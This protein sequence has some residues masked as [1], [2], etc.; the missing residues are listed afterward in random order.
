MLRSLVI[1][2]CILLLSACSQFSKQASDVA[3]QQAAKVSP[4]TAQNSASHPNRD[5]AQSE[6]KT[7]TASLNASD[8]KAQASNPT[9]ESPNQATGNDAENDEQSDLW[10]HIRDDFRLAHIDHSRI[11]KQKNWYGRHPNYMTRVSKRASPYLYFIVNELKRRDMP[12][13][14]ALLPIVESAYDPF[15]YSHGRA[16]GL[17]QFT[18]PTA[19]DFGLHKNWWYD[20]RR[21]IEASTQAALNY[22]QKL[23]KRFD[24]D[25]LLALAAYNAGGGT[26]NKAIKRN[27][28]RDKATDFWS[29]KLPKET[30]IYVPR[31]LGLSRLVAKPEKNGIELVNVPNKPFYRRFNLDYQLDLAQAAQLAELP[32]DEFYLL[33]PAYNRWATTPDGPQ[34]ILIPVSQANAFASGLDELDQAERVGWTRY[35][36]KNGDTLG[37]IANDHKLSVKELKRIN[38]LSNNTIRKGQ[39]LFIPTASKPGKHYSFSL[40]ERVARSQGKTRATR[41]KVKSGDS[42]WSISRR[43]G[44]N[45]EDIARWNKLSVNGTLKLGQKLLI[46]PKNARYAQG[47]KRISYKVRKGDSIALIAKRFGTSINAIVRS[48]NLNPKRY[49]QP[50]QALTVLVNPRRG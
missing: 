3:G 47:K 30:Q 10:Q 26:V 27:K 2:S 32:M 9:V 48:N 15:A 36:V 29:L 42:L 35:E 22:L 6:S 43:Y 31:L 12:M 11:N 4:N 16:S 41:Y 39:A 44:V 19:K 50:G 17:W 23:H 40:N 46:Y 34:H 1:T 49:L 8:S 7:A 45:Y 5:T 24:G 25:W 21:D 28:R 38:Q 14:L 37:K 13:E 33:N 18:P 20:G